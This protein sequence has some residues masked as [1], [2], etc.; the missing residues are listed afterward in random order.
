MLRLILTLVATLALL[1]GC[2][3]PKSFIDPTQSKLTYES[4]KRPSTPL[5][6]TLVTEFQRNGEHFPRADPTLRDITERVLRA[7]GVI[8]P[9]TE[10]AVGQVRVVVNNVADRGA[11]AAKGFGTGL[12][13]GLIGTTVMDAYELTLVVNTGGKTYSSSVIKHSLFTAIGNTTT[14]EGVET[15]PIG[16]AF[17]KVVEQMLLRALKEAQ[18][19]SALDASLNTQ[20]TSFLLRPNHSFKR[21]VNG[22]RPS[23][24]A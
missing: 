1:A 10:A 11:A 16:V 13:F 19:G 12:T 22:L 15:M 24:A 2:V 23:P 3:S 14:P 4:V 21:T 7:S 8:I 17:Q 9:T 5:K 20:S 6:L 18:D